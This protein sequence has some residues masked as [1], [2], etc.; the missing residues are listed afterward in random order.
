MVTI[1]EIL[2]LP[3][4]RGARVVAGRRGLQ[5]RVRWCHVSEVT[6]I[7]RLLSGGEVLLTTGM[8]LD[9][10]PEQQA[11]YI[12]S[13]YQRGVAGLMLELERKF[14]AA[15]PAMVEAANRVDFPLIT[16]AF[17]TP[18]V[19]VTEAVHKLILSVDTRA[20]VARLELCEREL[21]ADLD[22]GRLVDEGELRQRL[23]AL[24]R[25]LPDHAWLAVA[26]AEP[27][28]ALEVLRTAAAAEIGAENW[29]AA[30]QSGEVRLLAFATDRRKLSA[31]L[32]GFAGHLATAAV[33]ASRCVSKAAA[34]AACFGEARQTMRLRRQSHGISPLFAETGVYQLAVG[35]SSEELQQY[36][37]E[38]LLSLIQ[39]DRARGTNLCQTLRV[40]LDDRLS[41]AEAAQRLHLTRQGLYHRLE[42]MAAILGCSLDD[43][44]CR[45]ALGVALRFHDVITVSRPSS[46]QQ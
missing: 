18:F 4:L 28:G 38:H 17:D 9:S 20:A 16:L 3:I 19:R 1:S 30:A 15:P 40:V 21:L 11:A 22:E 33:G 36:V 27:E 44:E 26:V 46:A 5:A 42:R 32:Q 31:S 23:K 10:V 24:E 25:R 29:V 41:I 34:L 14:P 45:L 8:A 7:A 37:D 6:D 39:Y 2:R 35:R 12:E 43:S 13:L